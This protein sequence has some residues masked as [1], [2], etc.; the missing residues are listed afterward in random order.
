MRRWAATSM[1]LACGCNALWG[2]DSLDYRQA[3]S[4]AATGA[5]MGGSGGVAGQGQGASGGAGG[6]G[7]VGGSGQGG[8]GA[9]ECGNGVID[10]TEQCDDANLVVGDGCHGCQVECS[11]ADQLHDLQTHHCYWLTALASSWASA[12]SLC[13]DDGAE[14][15]AITSPEEQ[16]L[17]E[18]LATVEAF[19]GATDIAVEGTFE[20]V[21]GEA[22][23]FT[24]WANGE[25]N[26]E[27]GE[28]CLLI[29][30]TGLWNDGNCSSNRPGLC[31]RPPP[32]GE[33]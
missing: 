25:P 28:D 14:L 13:V 4:S 6:S 32:Q 12:R 9:A 33:R 18:P 21:T 29:L 3:T 15:A 23:S 26:D 27:Y 22:W 7:G 17:V 30:P 24:N 11:G 16:A 5:P 2:I 19:L 31:E 8:A 20:W 10:G 1:I